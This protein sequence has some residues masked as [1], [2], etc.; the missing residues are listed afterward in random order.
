M[1]FVAVALIL[2]LAGARG[3]QE[4][5]PQDRVDELAKK[6]EEL[7]KRVTAL[8]GEREKLAKENDDLKKQLDTMEQYAAKAAE[9][10][11]RLKQALAD[12]GSRGPDPA[13]KGNENTGRTE[14]P[15]KSGP[16]DGPVAPV[17]GKILSLNAELGFVIVNLGEDDGVKEG[18]MFEVV[19]P[20]RDEKGAVSNELLGKAVFEKYVETMKATQSKLKV[21][22]GSAEKMKY[23]DAVVA[24]RRMDPLPPKETPE[25]E[26]AAKADARK[27]KV[28]GITNDTYFLDLCAKDGVK[29]SDLVYVQRDRRIIA[30]LRLDQVAKDYSAGKIV[31][32]SKIA[33][34]AQND[35]ILLKDPKTS[36]VGK[37]KRID[38]KFGIYIEIGQL[39]GA[40][41]GMQFEVRRQ[42]RTLGR[43]AVKQLGPHHSVCE[44]VG[45]LK[46]DE[47]Q[48]DDF[49]ESVV[50]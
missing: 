7:Q 40:K 38:D 22:E 39:Q 42:G 43:I 1:Q 18:W 3:P 34:P 35:E 26:P 6:V 48:M 19:R 20:H 32:G 46:A 31:E 36:L 21:V 24:Y 50:E 25:K 23:G 4:T 9:T 28:V 10:I 27:F 33:E 17:H 41:L 37:V 13:G 49:V 47:V 45:A 30:R 11:T 14:G 16:P 44:P 29:P 2:S 12:A 5:P 15:A 8:E